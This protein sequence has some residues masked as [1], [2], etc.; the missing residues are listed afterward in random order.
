MDVGFRAAVDDAAGRCHERFQPADRLLGELGLGR[1]LH[2]FAH[3]RAYL[4]QD[5]GH[6]LGHLVKV[7]ADIGGG[8][9]IGL[10]RKI[11]R[12]EIGS[13]KMLGIGQ[14]RPGEKILGAFRDIGNH[15]K[16]HDGFV[17]MIEIVGSKSGLW[18]DVGGA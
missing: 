6:G 4:V 17:E 5:R 11:A 15:F 3:R 14:G 1:V 13:P 8:G 10:D 18:I 16:Q 2:G 9:F 12:L 7:R